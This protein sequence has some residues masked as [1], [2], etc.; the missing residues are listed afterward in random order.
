MLKRTCLLFI[1]LISLTFVSACDEDKQEIYLYDQYYYGMTREQVKKLA[2]VSPCQDNMNQL[3]RHNLVPFFRTTWH[4]R[5]IFKHDR[6]VGVQ[7]AHTD[8]DKASKLINSWLDSGYRYLPVAIISDGKELDL[9]A[10]IKFSGK[11][12]AR[13]AVLN[14]TRATAQDRESTYLYLDLDGRED[15]LNNYRSFHD[16]L[17][18]APRDIVGIEQIVNEK[19]VIINFIAPIAEWQDRARRNR[20]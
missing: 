11:E 7:L 9:F 16:I 4:Q 14:F 19:F 10:E 13:Q 18:Y 8:P 17:S 6:L 3:C 1:L 12:G 15:V 5:F 2:T 20:P